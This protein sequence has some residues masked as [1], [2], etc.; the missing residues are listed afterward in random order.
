MQ[1]R[2]L[3]QSGG[4]AMRSSG[5][6]L[7]AVREIQT[8]GGHPRVKRAGEEPEV[9]IHSTRCKESLSIRDTEW[10]QHASDGNGPWV[11]QF[12]R[13]GSYGLEQTAV[14]FPYIIQ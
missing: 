6:L 11:S 9:N 5:A 14:D 13:S 7:S 1:N 2:A 3:E 10:R 12:S 8:P 4:I